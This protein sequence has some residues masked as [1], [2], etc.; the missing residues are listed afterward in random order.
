[1][2][3]D[4]ERRRYYNAKLHQK[5]KKMHVHLSKELR[6]KL[7][8][9][10][11]AVLVR[12]GDKV[13]VM[14]GPGKGT[15]AKVSRVSHLNMK[16]YLEGVT[17]RTAKGR[18]I[19]KPLQPSNLLLIEL[20]QTKE[21]KELFTEEAFKKAEKKAEKPRMEAKPEPAEVKAEI[22]TQDTKPRVESIKPATVQAEVVPE[23]PGAAKR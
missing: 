15:T 20:E 23:K 7:K 16:V 9:K 3:S 21:R 5:T 17:V 1:M 6:G 12:E 18:E 22:K 19:M 10:R 14:R 2:K 11:R 13:R 4:T 8:R